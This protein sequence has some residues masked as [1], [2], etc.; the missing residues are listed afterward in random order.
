MKN[1]AADALT[2]TNKVIGL[3][4]QLTKDVLLERLQKQID[5]NIENGISFAYLNILPHRVSLDTVME[6]EKDLLNLGFHARYNFYPNLYY[7]V[8]IEW[9]KA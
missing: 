4:K 1:T 9:H 6:L 7:I 8:T 5:L 2:K 3:T